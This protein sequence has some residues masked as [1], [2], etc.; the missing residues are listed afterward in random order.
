MPEL[1]LGFAGAAPMHRA[2]QAGRQALDEGIHVSGVL[3]PRPG[4][5]RSNAVFGPGGQCI[6]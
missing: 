3:R 2:G 5:C 1:A 6:S 4:G